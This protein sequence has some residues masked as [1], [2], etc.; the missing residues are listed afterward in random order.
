MKME[1]AKRRVA[2]EQKPPGNTAFKALV[3]ALKDPTSTVGQLN[4]S[5]AYREGYKA[6]EAGIIA[7]ANPYSAGTTEEGDW[8]DGW[9][10]A[11]YGEAL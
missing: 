11:F 4:R 10:M 1:V 9:E 7:A 6:C 3:D 5:D 2:V 8:L